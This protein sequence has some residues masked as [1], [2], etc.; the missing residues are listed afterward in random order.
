[1]SLYPLGL[2]GGGGGTSD[3]QLIPLLTEI[4]DQLKA[5]YSKGAS[6]FIKYLEG[7]QTIILDKDVTFDPNAGYTITSHQ[8]IASPGLAAIQN[9][10]SQELKTL[11]TN[12]FN[13]LTADY[14][15][16]DTRFIKYLEDTQ[17]IILDK[18]VTFDPN[19]GYTITE[20][21]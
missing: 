13:Q 4:L 7:T 19:T 12:I 8:V 2:G 15:K 6:R 16:G 17:T 14:F 20:H 3:Q 5:D 9:L 11:L 21:Q 1:M 18:N 10:T